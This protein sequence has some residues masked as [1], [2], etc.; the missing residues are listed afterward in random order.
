MKNL[1]VRGVFVLLFFLLAA[2][3]LSMSPE[4][5]SYNDAVIHYLSEAASETGAI[6]VIAAIVADYRGFDTLGETVVLFTA[7]IAVASVLRQPKKE[8]DSSHE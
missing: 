8:G 7:A 6:N 4:L 3:L 2:G 5:L 1:L